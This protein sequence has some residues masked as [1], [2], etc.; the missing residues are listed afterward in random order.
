[1]VS[2]KTGAR[3]DPTDG[4]RSP[5]LYAGGNM[6][7]KQAEELVKKLDAARRVKR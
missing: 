3:H 4:T 2:L 1:M 6:N 7:W 5:T